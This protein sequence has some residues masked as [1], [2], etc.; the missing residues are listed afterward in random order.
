MR[1]EH[2]QY[3]EKINVCPEIIGN[4]VIGQFFIDVNL[5][6]DNYLTLFQNNEFISWSSKPTRCSELVRAGWN[7]HITKTMSGSI[8]IK[9][10]QIGG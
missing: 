7:S 4:H 9:Y 10:F 3:P 2:T 5:N 8:S 1:E 6:G